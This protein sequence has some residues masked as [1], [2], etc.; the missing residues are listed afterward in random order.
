MATRASFYFV[1]ILIW[2]S[3]R[4]V[5]RNLTFFHICTH[6]IDHATFFCPSADATHSFETKARAFAQHFLCVTR[7]PF[8]SRPTAVETENFLVETCGFKQKER[9][10]TCHELFLYD[11]LVLPNPQASMPQRQGLSR[12]VLRSGWSCGTVIQC[13]NHLVVILGWRL[14]FVKTQ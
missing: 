5:S 3:V 12:R 4:S 9:T 11:P 14:E 13:L 6:A 2:T 10:Q 8:N 1:Y 7:M